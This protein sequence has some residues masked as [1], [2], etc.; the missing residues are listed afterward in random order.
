MDATPPGTHLCLLV[1]DDDYTHKDEFFTD[2]WA[3]D[4]ALR[5]LEVR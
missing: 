3:A 1:K 4:A 2:L 5:V